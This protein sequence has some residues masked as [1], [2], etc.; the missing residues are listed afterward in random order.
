MMRFITKKISANSE[1]AKFIRLKRQCKLVINKLISLHK[2]HHTDYCVLVIGQPESG[3]SILCASSGELLFSTQTGLTQESTISNEFAFEIYLQHNI[4]LLHIPQDFFLF[5]EPR[6]QHRAWGF[7]A[8]QLK[9]QRPYLAIMRCLVN[10]DLHDFLTR[11]KASIDK[12]LSEMALALNALSGGLRTHLDVA[13]FFT[14]ADLIPGF[15]EFFDRES[16]EFLE[17]S[18][19]ISLENDAPEN[20]TAECEQLIKKLNERLLWSLHHE[21]NPEQLHLIKTFPL[22]LETIKNK[23]SEIL[24]GFLGQWNRNKFLTPTRLYFTSCRQFRELTESSHSEAAA[25]QNNQNNGHKHFFIQHALDAQC[26]SQLKSPNAYIETLTRITFIS[27]CSLVFLA[28]IFYTSQQFSRHVELIRAVNQTLESVQEFSKRPYSSLTLNKVTRELEVIRTSLEGIEKD[29]H[30]LLFEKYIFTR[31]SKL[32]TQLKNI[33][34]RV[35]SQQWLPLIN[36]RLENYINSHLSTEPANAYIAFNIY[37]MLSQPDWPIETDYI[38]AHLSDLL[39]SADEPIKLL[40][41]NI[42]KNILVV[43]ENSPFIQ[44]SRA[45]FQGLPA[46]KLAYILLF[47]SLDTHHSLNVAL[48]TGSKQP[49]LEIEKKFALIPEIYTANLFSAVYKKRLLVVAK[50]TISGNKILGNYHRQNITD[51]EKDLLPQLKKEYLKLYSDAWEQAIKH[52]SLTQTS[53]LQ[54]FSNQLKILTSVDSPILSLL[55]L[56]QANTLIPDIEQASPF[57]TA[58]NDTLTQQSTPENSALYHSFAFL[59]KLSDQVL[60][61]QNSEDQKTATCTLL[62]QE[63]AATNAN[64]SDAQQIRYLASQLPEPIQTWWLQIVDTYYAL[65][66]Q[67]AVDC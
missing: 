52:V 7:L 27:L 36:Q 31:D 45:F 43:D 18:W 40:P 48:T 54:D 9:H 19:G 63:Y 42:Q 13:L 6:Q 38:N 39:G 22:A 28:F 5:S 17:Q 55:K 25:K 61:I 4:L 46:D 44:S 59:I 56:S 10:I 32:E 20:L 2:Q 24:P 26:Q 64:P 29:Q 41:E 3:K 8:T 58:F 60:K 66:K 65:L 35:I 57:L 51:A 53:T 14:K 50:E 15:N 21:V 47:S 16:K 37:L 23:F 33:Y 62:A 12:R 34:Q 67:S 11:S 1:H 30:S 49:S